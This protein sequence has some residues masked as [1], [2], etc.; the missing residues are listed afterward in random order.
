MFG[1]VKDLKAEIEYLRKANDELRVQL[2]AMSNKSSEY[3]NAKLA[4]QK[5]PVDMKDGQ[6]V[7]ENI[8]SKEPKNEKEKK[9]QEQAIRLTKKIF[10]GC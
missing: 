10:A 2:V 1:R 9:Q 4:S 6:A 3:W 8:K 5:K 7:L